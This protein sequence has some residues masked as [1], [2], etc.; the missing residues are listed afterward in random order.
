[1]GSERFFPELPCILLWLYVI[2]AWAWPCA[3][4]LCGRLA[5]LPPP[6]R[7]R[8]T[9]DPTP[10]PCLTVT[11]PC[12]AYAQAAPAPVAPSAPPLLLTSQRGRPRQ[13]DVSSQ[14]CPQ[15]HCAY[16]GSVG[17]GGGCGASSQGVAATSLPFWTVAS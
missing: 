6:P 16:Y 8:S 1:M 12:A 17:C 4:L 9:G 13:V 3:R 15:G 10:F 7:R 11:S 14:F 5:P 2:L